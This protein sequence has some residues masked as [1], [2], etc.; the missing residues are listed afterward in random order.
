MND[1]F[2]E[3]LTDACKRP[4]MYVGRESL[5]DL[6]TYLTGY[7]HG[8]EDA[9]TPIPFGRMAF[10][11]WVEA[12]FGIFS[13]AWNWVRILQHEYGDDQAAIRALPGLYDDFCFETDRMSDDQL[14]DMMQATLVAKRGTKCWSP[15]DAGT[16]TSPRA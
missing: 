5:W 15:D 7:C 14:W 6:A 10:Q 3:L 2:R 13:A 4:G 16:W 12:K 8:S 11:R 1:V 9:G